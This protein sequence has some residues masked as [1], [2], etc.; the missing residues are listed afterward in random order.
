MHNPCVDTVIWVLL[1]KP[2]PKPRTVSYWHNIRCGAFTCL[3][4][5]RLRSRGLGGQSGDPGGDDRL[6]AFLERGVQ[7]QV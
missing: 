2:G 1:S 5:E 4:S 7:C 6:G 3:E